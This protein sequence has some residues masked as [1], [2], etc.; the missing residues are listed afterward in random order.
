MRLVRCLEI[1]FRR[2]VLKL[3][4]RNA[5]RDVEMVRDVA[6]QLQHRGHFPFGEQIDL[7]IQLA[8]FVGLPRQPILAGEHEQREEDR[9]ERDGH[10]EER[11]GKRV[12][13]RDTW[14]QAD[15]GAHPDAEPHHV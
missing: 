6:Q 10:G 7:Q 3:G 13:R 8:P 5:G 2:E 15:I 4:G 1:G 11:K 9:L 14:D 12:K